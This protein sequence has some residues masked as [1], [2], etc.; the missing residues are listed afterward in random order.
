[1]KA[2]HEFAGLLEGPFDPTHEFELIYAHHGR[3]LT[4]GNFA[5]TA[6]PQQSDLY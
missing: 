5:N 3:G 2:V 6:A 1:M 4:P